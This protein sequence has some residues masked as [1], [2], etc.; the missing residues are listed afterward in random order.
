MTVQ[1]KIDIVRNV[2]KQKIREIEIDLTL[3]IGSGKARESKMI[4]CKELKEC[5]SF[6]DKISSSKKILKF[7]SVFVK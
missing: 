2:L 3:P 6:L 1:E 4:Q 5:L 7:L